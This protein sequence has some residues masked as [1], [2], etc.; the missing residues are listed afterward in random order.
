MGVSYF[1]CVI[2][3]RK[4]AHKEVDVHH[5]VVTHRALNILRGSVKHDFAVDLEVKRISESSGV[6]NIDWCIS[7]IFPGMTQ[8][9]KIKPS[10]IEAYMICSTSGAIGE[11]MLE[12][13]KTGILDSNSKV[14]WRPKSVHPIIVGD[15]GSAGNTDVIM[16]K[17][18]LDTVRNLLVSASI[19]PTIQ[20]VDIETSNRVDA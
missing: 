8:S 2:P 17:L 10:K 14:K 20:V 3:S 9:L 6:V 5:G 16:D 12:I 19:Q 4:A 11:C 13:K 1:K 18:N 7:R 15:A